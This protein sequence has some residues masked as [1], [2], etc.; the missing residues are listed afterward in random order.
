L[1]VDPYQGKAGEVME[2]I[3]LNSWEWTVIR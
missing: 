3:S 1:P 2:L